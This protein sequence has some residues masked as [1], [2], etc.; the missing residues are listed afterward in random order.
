MKTQFF[1]SLMGL[2]ISVGAIGLLG[3][4]YA[5]KRWY[6]K[7]PIH[8]G[9]EVVTIVS[10]FVALGGLSAYKFTEASYH[11]AKKSTHYAIDATV[12]GTHT[13]LKAGQ[14]AISGTIKYF[15]VAILEGVGETYQHFENKWEKQKIEEF[16][17]LQLKIISNKK[18]IQDKK[19]LV[20]IVLEVSNTSTKSIDFKALINHQL[21]LLKDKENHY[22]PITF[23][24]I[25]H[26]NMII[27]PATTSTQE[28]DIFIHN[29]NYPILLSTPQK[30]IELKD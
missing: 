29:E 25:N 12:D 8:I 11:Y 22:Y 20:H 23:N 26:Q 27:P 18:T 10:I 7:E 14:S 30:T 17:N 16:K 6:K 4:Y 9:G 5:Y 13:L 15:S 19:S 1:A 24:E 21:L 3:G 28:I 2:G